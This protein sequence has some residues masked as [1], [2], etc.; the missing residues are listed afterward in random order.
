MKNTNHIW[1]N[2]QNSNFPYIFEDNLLVVSNTYFE[3]NIQKLGT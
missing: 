3:G 1:N 2:K